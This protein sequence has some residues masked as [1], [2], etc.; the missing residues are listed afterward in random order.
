MKT[1]LVTL[2]LLSSP[3]AQA[4]SSVNVIID[5]ESY[6]CSKGGNGSGNLCECVV[7][8]DSFDRNWKWAA[9]KRG[10]QQRAS[11]STSKESAEEDCQKWT[12]TNSTCYQ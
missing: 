11:S 6:S 8:Y 3:L 4:A 1:L 10:A 9:F 7:S 2:A 5:G 12:K